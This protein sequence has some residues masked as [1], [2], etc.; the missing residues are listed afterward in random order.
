MPIEYVGRLG[1][2]NTVW[3]DVGGEIDRRAG[4]I[5]EI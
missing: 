3:Y 1:I 5:T 4:I 2:V